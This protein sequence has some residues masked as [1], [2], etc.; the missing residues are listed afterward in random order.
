M[1]DYDQWPPIEGDENDSV[2]CLV[3]VAGLVAIGLFIHFCF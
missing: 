3:A 1:T 2:G